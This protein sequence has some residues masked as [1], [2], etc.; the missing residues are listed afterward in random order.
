MWVHLIYRLD[1]SSIMVLNVVLAPIGLV[2][3]I[4]VPFV[5]MHFSSMRVPSLTLFRPILVSTFAG[6]WSGQVASFFLDIVVRS[7]LGGSPIAGWVFSFWVVWQ[8]G[9]AAFSG[10]FFVS[11]SAVLLAYYRK[12]LAQRPEARFY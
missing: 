8:L 7:L 4:I 11:L 1:P 12:T 10:V 9:V 6:C 2:V 3:G 5:V